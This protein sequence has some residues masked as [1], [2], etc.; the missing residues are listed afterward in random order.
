MILPITAYGDTVLIKKAENIKPEYP[1]LNI[2]IDNMFD[3][4]YNAHGIGLAAPQVGLS[5]RLFIVDAQPFDEDRIKKGEEP[6][7]FKK[8]FINPQIIEEWGDK[9]AFS[10]GCLSIP[11]IH[12][13]VTR[14]PNLRIKYLD[15]NFVEHIEEYDGIIARIIQHEYD[16]IEGKL[17]TDRLG[18]LTKT[19]LRKRL[20]KISKGE[21]HVNY[22]MRFTSY[23]KSK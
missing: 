7:N 16:H 10:E 22:K 15:T 20:E 4:M 19:M 14:Y 8:V 9:W 21:I 1:D 6:Y 17:F 2:L 11:D 12:E 23:R 3:T 13:K 18:S 5:I